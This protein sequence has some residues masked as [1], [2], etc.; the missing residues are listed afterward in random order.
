MVDALQRG[1]SQ[2]YF[3]VLATATLYLPAFDEPGPQ[4]LVTV[5]S[6]DDTYLIVFTSPEALARRLKGVDS[7]RTTSYPELRAKW[8]DP[9]WMLAVDP[10]TPIQGF[11]P[12]AI[13]SEGAA[14]RVVLPA[15]PDDVVPGDG[16]PVPDDAPD[17]GPVTFDLDRVRPANQL[18]RDMVDSLRSADVNGVVRT[19]VLGEVHVPTQR[20]V[21]GPVEPGPDFPWR[22]ADVRIRTVPVFTSA[23]RLVD[24]VPLGAPSVAVPFLDLVLSW[25]GPAWRLAVNPGTAL[26]LTFPGEHV[27]GF[28]A[29]AE[30]LVHGPVNPDGAGATDARKQPVEALP[31][32]VPRAEAPRGRAEVPP[33]DVPP[34]NVS[35]AEVS[36]ADAP[37]AD[38]PRP[39][40]EPP[41]EVS[42]P[43]VRAAA[44]T[45]EAP[46]STVEASR[47]AAQLLQKI[48]PHRQVESYLHGHWSQVS[49]P[50]H[51]YAELGEPRTPA[52]LHAATGGAG[53]AFQ[54]DDPWVHVIRWVA[55]CPEVY[56][57]F[58]DGAGS[59]T[60]LSAH[61][62]ALPHGAQLHRLNRDAEPTWLASF[63][64]DV[65]QWVPAPEPGLL[66]QAL[67][68]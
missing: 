14:G 33:A 26:E 22:E 54:A 2:A 30:E 38:V 17:S 58:P 64:A 61:A 32:D 48:V 43:P 57:P 12:I 59:L 41:T 51:R 25:P 5:K 3:Q 56:R 21:A 31:A 44:S 68:S 62:V 67:I 6:G 34:A 4:Q 28:V 60:V 24:A 36:R 11:M 23:S 9:L 46:R 49:G 63:D 52:E 13:V 40:V 53:D 50:V 29:W 8:P 66:R 42:L 65:R 7:F 37:L 1:D 47:P 35:P 45:V 39:R 55:D 20:R 16:F 18:E 15:V 10:D 27:P 19:L